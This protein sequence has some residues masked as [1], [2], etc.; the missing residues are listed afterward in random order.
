MPQ[1][2]GQEP[3]HDHN[4]DER[5]SGHSSWRA[6]ELLFGGGVIV[7]ALASS[8]TA[9]WWAATTET[10]IE[11]LYDQE[12]EIAQQISGLDNVSLG[13]R[14]TALETQIVASN[15]QLDSIERKM[16]RLLQKRGAEID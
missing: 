16:D 1:G 12:K 14:I 2:T 9:I 4:D 6:A 15:R 5:G 3:S 13:N 11:N 10:R 8:V 7:W